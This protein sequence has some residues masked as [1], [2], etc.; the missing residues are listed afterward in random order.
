MD[1]IQSRA[2]KEALQDK[3][4]VRDLGIDETSFQKRHEYVTFWTKRR[5]CVMDIFDD[6]KASKLNSWF[7]K[8]GNIQ[9]RDLK[10]HFHGYA[11]A[12]HQS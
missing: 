7:T 3:V 5:T 6:R 10:K 12:F 4:N 2:V 9:F 11:G 8:A 1:G